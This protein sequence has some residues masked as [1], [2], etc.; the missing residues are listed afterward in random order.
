MTAILKGYKNNS[1]P[2]PAFGTKRAYI[3]VLESEWKWSRVR[4]FANT[5]FTFQISAPST[6]LFIIRHFASGGG[7]GRAFLVMETKQN[8]GGVLKIFGNRRSITPADIGNDN[9]NRDKE[10][11]NWK[12]IWNV[13]TYRMTA[14]GG[15]AL[16]MPLVFTP[17]RSSGPSN[18]G[19]SKFNFS[20]THWAYSDSSIS[21]NCSICQELEASIMKN[22]NADDYEVDLVREQALGV[23]DSKSLVH[24]DVKNDHVGLLPIWQDGQVVNLKPVL[25]DLCRVTPK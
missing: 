13:N 14:M 1:T 25:I 24:N 19:P 15:P 11:A 4:R 2:L 17:S 21:A 20:A 18:S 23:L 7:D 12:R 5:R 10:H 3:E 9:D 22:F 6:N 8:F 16:L